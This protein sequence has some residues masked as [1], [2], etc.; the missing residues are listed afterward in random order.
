MAF[1]PLSKV[2]LI[3]TPLDNT[4]KNTI[5][6]DD[7]GDQH[8]YFFNHKLHE[9]EGVTYMRKDNYFDVRE[10]ID[11]L[12]N[13][14][15]AAY[16]NYNFGTKWFYAFITKM[17]YINDHTTRIFIETDVYQ[18]WL[19]D[20]QIKPSFVVREHVA[21]DTI[22]KHLVDEQL[23]TGE[24]LMD[25]YS[26]SG[27][28]GD[29][30][31]ILA[32]SDN[33]PFGNSELVGNI[34]S[35][36]VTGLTYYPFPNNATGL[37][38]LKNAINIYATNAKADAIVMLFTVP[39]LIIPFV[40]DETWELGDPIPQNAAYGVSIFNEAK[41]LTDVNGYTPRNNKMHT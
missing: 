25:S 2:Y 30:W 6:F 13:V 27:K 41:R 28:M 29:S 9:F 23:E 16:Q 26:A 12:W 3:D 21:D 10:H 4:Y 35:N 14:N 8:L 38:W 24:Y 17:E 11:N 37:T 7:I 19:F 22:G 33:T 1:T 36:L 18:T 5:H 34:Y 31:N 20:V 32:V 39:K 40:D 15:Y